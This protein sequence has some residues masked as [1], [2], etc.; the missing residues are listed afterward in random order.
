MT[1]DLDLTSRCCE[2]SDQSASQ[3][4]AAL[5]YSCQKLDAPRPHRSADTPGPL[6]HPAR[7]ASRCAL[8]GVSMLC[9]EAKSRQVKGAPTRPGDTIACWPQRRP[10]VTGHELLQ[11]PTLQNMQACT[12]HKYSCCWL[13]A[14]ISSRETG[15]PGPCST[16]WTRCMLQDTERL[17]QPL[18]QISSALALGSKSQADR[19]DGG[20]Q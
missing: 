2:Q 6:S 10:Q 9:S 19:R 16:C 4:R 12:Q 13:A 3:S 1:A 18:P 5:S 17:Q 14:S 20:C 15:L 11:A 8:T 7:F